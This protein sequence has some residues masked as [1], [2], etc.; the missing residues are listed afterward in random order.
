VEHRQ[1][2]H[3]G[4]SVSVA[5][6]GTNEFASR[7]HDEAGWSVIAGAASGEPVRANG[8]TAEGSLNGAEMAAVD[9]L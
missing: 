6:L 9:E 1:P 7:L 4:L 5:G 2:G 3:S 8:A